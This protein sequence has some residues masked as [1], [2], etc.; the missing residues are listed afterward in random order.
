MTDVWGLKRHMLSP[1]LFSKAGS[2]KPSARGAGSKKQSVDTILFSTCLICKRAIKM[3]VG[4]SA[5][6]HSWNVGHLESIRIAELPNDSKLR[7]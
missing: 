4:V 5:L 3:V 1:S 2:E 7:V 6:I